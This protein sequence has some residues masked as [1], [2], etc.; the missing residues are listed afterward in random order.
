[1]KPVNFG[2][3]WPFLEHHQQAQQGI[4][5]WNNARIDQIIN[6]K[7][8]PFTS[9]EQGDNIFKEPSAKIKEL[10]LYSLFIFLYFCSK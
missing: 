9:F 10:I 5:V 4:C 7:N 3:P 8:L 1:M 2:D 6:F